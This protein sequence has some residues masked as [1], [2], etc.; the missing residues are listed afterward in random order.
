MLLDK[1][2]RMA[3]GDDVEKVGISL[4]LLPD[5]KDEL[6]RVSK[7][8]GVT[9]NALIT[10]IIELVLRGDSEADLKAVEKI[11]LLQNSIKQ[12]EAFHRDG[13]SQI[14]LEN[15]DVIYVDRELETAYKKLDI[16][17]GGR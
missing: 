7:E 11:E 5:L 16:L 14:D 13:E 17:T 3:K 2:V 8:R 15:G 4:K 1:A 12:L 6:Q 10:S 9:M